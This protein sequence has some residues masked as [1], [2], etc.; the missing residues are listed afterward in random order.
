M[1]T[2]AHYNQVDYLRAFREAHAQSAGARRTEDPALSALYIALARR[3]FGYAA[4]IRNGD[5][6]RTNIRPL[7]WFAAQ[8]R[9]ATLP[10]F[11][12]KAA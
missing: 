9:A 11:Q 2:H 4:A 3:S 10:S 1:A 12:N 6:S 8:V 7:S 5:W